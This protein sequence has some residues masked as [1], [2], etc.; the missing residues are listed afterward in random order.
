MARADQELVDV[1]AKRPVDDLVLR[2]AD[3][4]EQPSVLGR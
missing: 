2:G 3:V 4:L 1:G